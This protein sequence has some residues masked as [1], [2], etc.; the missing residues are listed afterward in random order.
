[1]G[2]TPHIQISIQRRSIVARRTVTTEKRT[3]ANIVWTMKATMRW[4]INGCVHSLSLFS[5]CHSVGFGEF[6]LVSKISLRIHDTVIFN[7]VWICGMED[8]FIFCAI[9]S[10]IAGSCCWIYSTN[11]KWWT[12][13]NSQ[14]LHLKEL[15]VLVKGSTCNSGPR[16]FSCCRHANK[17]CGNKIQWKSQGKKPRVNVERAQCAC[18]VSR[19]IKIVSYRIITSVHIKNRIKRNDCMRNEQLT[20]FPRC[21]SFFYYFRF[22]SH[23]FF[24]LFSSTTVH[25]L[26]KFQVNKSWNKMRF[27][28]G[29]GEACLRNFYI[30]NSEQETLKIFA[31][32]YE[33]LPL[34]LVIIVRAL[35]EWKILFLAKF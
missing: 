26:A 30:V 10:G 18:A 23:P 15:C 19:T 3:R 16:C 32:N 1:M 34:P 31:V 29:I 13:H 8:G 25:R 17:I 5:M 4:H 9:I 35:P 14:Y 7:G 27:T 12:L 24:G 6:I 22:S 20:H 21:C 2:Q 11:G 33:P 28:A